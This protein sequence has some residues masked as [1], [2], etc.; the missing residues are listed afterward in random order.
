MDATADIDLQVLQGGDH[1]EEVLDLL[2]AAERAAGI[3]MVDESE[4][5]RLE[6]LAAGAIERSGNWVSILAREGGTPVGYAGFVDAGSPTEDDGTDPSAGERLASGDVAVP[7]AFGPGG[8]V[9]RRLLDHL[10]EVA[11]ARQLDGL[12]VWMRHAHADDLEV[13][14]EHGFGIA[15]RLAVLGR[16]HKEMDVPTIPGVT[17]RTYRPDLDDAGV[18]D[19]LAAAYAGTGDEGWDIARFRERRELSW[20]RPDDLLVAVDGSGRILGLHWLKR[21]G[22]G[23]GEVYNLA[24]HPDAQGRRLGPMLLAAGLEHL[25]DIGCQEVLLWV[26]RANERAVDLYTSQGFTTRWDDVALRWPGE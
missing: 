17:I 5:E 19:V 23:V 26:D 15:R 18:V 25:R 8:P 21:R 9:L 13:A 3:P 20:F 7:R 14:Q 24:I 1:V 16:T 12:L 4:R 6:R 2:D 22:A 11:D 10:V